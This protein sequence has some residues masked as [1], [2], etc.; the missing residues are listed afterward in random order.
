MLSPIPQ[1]DLTEWAEQACLEPLHDLLLTLHDEEHE[2]GHPGLFLQ[3]QALLE[4]PDRSPAID[5]AL[6]PWLL[7][8]VWEKPD[9]TA[10]QQAWRVLQDVAA[11]AEA[12]APHALQVLLHHPHALTRAEVLAFHDARN[13]EY[14]EELRFIDRV[15]QV[16]RDD[17]S[18]VV[19]RAGWAFLDYQSV[20]D[21]S[22]LDPLVAG[23]SDPA[24]EVRLVASSSLATLYLTEEDARRT[25][26]DAQEDALSDPSNRW[27]LHR[28]LADYARSAPLYGDPHRVMFTLDLLSGLSEPIPFHH[29]ALAAIHWQAPWPTQGPSMEHWMAQA[30]FGSA[31]VLLDRL[32]LAVQDAEALPRLRAD[33]LHALYA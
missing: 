23:L 2:D 18:P 20:H 30:P 26:R 31:K 14:T 29:E 8:Y 7:R 27:I 17:P 11:D 4:H 5:A 28:L 9:A 32:E 33:A 12:L 21:A 22:S 25:R 16:V 6:E 1:L 15:W 24:A 13:A 3:F 19:R 10:T